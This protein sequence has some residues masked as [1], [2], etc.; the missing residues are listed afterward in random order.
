LKEKMNIKGGVEMWTLKEL[1]QK[2]A[3][4]KEYSDLPIEDFIDW[5]GWI[6]MIESHIKAL[7]D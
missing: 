4:A 6:Y 7:K 5:D 2:L 3:D 1:E